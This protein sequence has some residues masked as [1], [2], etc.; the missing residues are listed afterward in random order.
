M[1]VKYEPQPQSIQNTVQNQ[2]MLQ[3]YFDDELAV[4]KKSKTRAP[5]LS[6][7]WQ[8]DTQ[9]MLQIRMR[10]TPENAKQ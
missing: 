6:D 9:N 8:N 10:D 7:V 5:K 1:E 4:E 3:E 2:N